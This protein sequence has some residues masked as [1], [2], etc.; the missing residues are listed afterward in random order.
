MP[1]YFIQLSY[2]GTNYHGWQ[3]QDNTPLTVQHILQEKMSMILDIRLRLLDAVEQM[4]EFMQKI[5]M[6]ILILIKQT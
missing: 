4:Q 5:I 1:R 3:I 6:L 2:N